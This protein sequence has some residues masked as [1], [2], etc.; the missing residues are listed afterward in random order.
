MFPAAMLAGGS[1]RGMGIDT[2]YE[3]DEDLWVPCIGD[4]VA[5]SGFEF[6]GE[7]TRWTCPFCNLQRSDPNEG[8]LECGSCEG[9]AAGASEPAVM[10]G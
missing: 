6:A 4:E 8:F 9:I 1:Q 5:A 7:I 3:T 10:R 2:S